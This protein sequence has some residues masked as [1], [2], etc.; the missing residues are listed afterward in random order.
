MPNIKSAKKR[1][2]TDALKKNANKSKISS[3]RTAVKKAKTEIKNDEENGTDKINYDYN[4]LYI[5][6]LLTNFKY[7]PRTT[8]NQWV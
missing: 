3:M 1:V 2:K 5:L 4:E 6:V 8:F 7:C